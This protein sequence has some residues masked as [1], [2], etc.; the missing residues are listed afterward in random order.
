MS[1]HE[2]LQQPSGWRRVDICDPPPQVDAKALGLDDYH[3][4]IRQPMDLGTIK[5]R[6]TESPPAYHNAA[7]VLKDVQQVWSNC[8][9]YNDDDDA[10]M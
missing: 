10:I 5:E 9:T 7:E 6:L 2:Y 8:R 4:V 1:S 3:D